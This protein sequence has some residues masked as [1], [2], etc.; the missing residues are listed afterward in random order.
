[1]VQF[2]SNGQGQSSVDNEDATVVYTH[3]GLEA[4]EDGKPHW[5]RR[6]I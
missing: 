5:Q 2:L 3:D 6:N 4:V 1:M